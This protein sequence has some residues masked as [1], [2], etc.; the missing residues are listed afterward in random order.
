VK[1]SRGDEGRFDVS[2]EYDDAKRA[3]RKAGVPLRDVIRVAEQS[4]R[5]TLS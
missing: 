5:G 1:I 4:A 3:A 2:A